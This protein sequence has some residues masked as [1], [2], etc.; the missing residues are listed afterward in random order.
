MAIFHC[1]VSSPEAIFQVCSSDVPENLAKFQRFNF[2]IPGLWHIF[3]RFLD[4][5]APKRTPKWRSEKTPRAEDLQR[6][7]AEVARLAQDWE[8]VKK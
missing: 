2:Q 6:L 5:Q 4:D 1:Y 3:A 7:A 8:Q